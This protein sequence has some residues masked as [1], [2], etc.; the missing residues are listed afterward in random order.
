MKSIAVYFANAGQ[1]GRRVGRSRPG[2][3]STG[4][5]FSAD[6][7]GVACFDR[8]VGGHLLT[9][10]IQFELDQNGWHPY[11]YRDDATEE[12]IRAYTRVRDR[13]LAAINVPVQKHL[14]ERARKLDQ[15]LAEQGF[16][17]ADADSLYYPLFPDEEDHH[18]TN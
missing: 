14:R 3:Y 1:D 7:V 16:L 12:D 5:L 10:E 15:L 13:P 17:E 8:K 6:S 9:P 18:L 2:L 4:R 11:F